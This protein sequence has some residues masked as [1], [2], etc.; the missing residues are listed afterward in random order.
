MT[1]ERAHAYGRVATLLR[2]LGP[3]KLTPAEQRIREAADELIFCGSIVTDERAQ[4]AV[5]DV[6]TLGRHLVDAGRWSDRLAG[7]LLA[8]VY[9]CGPAESLGGVWRRRS[10]VRTH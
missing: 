2:E 10:A 8:A 4:D 7:R 3:A 9:G 5:R 1:A 6:G